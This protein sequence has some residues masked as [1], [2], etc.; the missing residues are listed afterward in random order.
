MKKAQVKC[1]FSDFDFETGMKIYGRRG[2]IPTNTLSNFVKNV[3]DL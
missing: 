2:T 1:E 3:A